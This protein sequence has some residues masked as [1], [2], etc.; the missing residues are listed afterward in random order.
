MVLTWNVC[1]FRQINHFWILKSPIYHIQT[2]SGETCSFT[3]HLPY[4]NTQS[5]ETC[6]FT[7]HLPYTN[8]VVRP[9]PLPSIYHIQTQSGETCS[10]TSHLPY[11][12]TQSGETCSFTSHHNSLAA[13]IHTKLSVFMFFVTYIQLLR[14]VECIDSWSPWMPC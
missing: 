9:A 14:E 1:L 7:S 8:R 3:S 12:N 10:F 13:Y 11:T 4:T 6:S 5:G 2:Q